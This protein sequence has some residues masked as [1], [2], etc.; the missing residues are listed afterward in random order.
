MNLFGSRLR[1]NPQPVPARSPLVD[2]LEYVLV[3]AAMIWVLARGTTLLGYHW[4]WYRVPQYLFTFENGRFVAGPLFHG[5]VVTLEITG[6]SL[7]LAFVIGIL[8]AFFRLSESIA[9]RSLARVYLEVVRNTPLLVQLFFIYFVLSPVF[10]IGR[11]ASGVLA[12]SLF[13]GAYVS[14]IL[15][16]GILSVPRGQWDAAYALG[17]GRLAIYRHIVFPQALR[18]VLPPLAGQGIALIKDS[19]LV[20]TIAVYELTMQGR[21]LIAETY[22]TF[23]LWFTVAGLYCLMT[24]SLSILVRLLEK[25]SAIDPAK[26]A[27]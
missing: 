16:A 10:G 12:L 1:R 2:V 27:R 20:S 19:A 9:A 17:L 15:R 4:Q 6:I 21:A 26:G 18:W 8:T 7:C 11:F 13:E 23:E 22:L 25:H 5:V 3:L 24:V 14:E